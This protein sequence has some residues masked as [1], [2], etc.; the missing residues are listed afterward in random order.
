MLLALELYTSNNTVFLSMYQSRYNSLSCSILRYI[1]GCTVLHCWLTIVLH[2]CPRTKAN[3]WT[4][5]QS[6]Y[7]WWTLNILA[8][9]PWNITALLHS[10]V[11]AL[12]LWNIIAYHLRNVFPHLARFVPAHFLGNLISWEPDYLGSSQHLSLGLS[13]HFSLGTLLHCIE[14][15]LEQWIPS[16]NGIFTGLH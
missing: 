8:L 12:F 7:S 13:Q 1:V 14:G 3:S 2:F 4:V 6:V 10:F 11:P 16:Q 5:M 15:T 9:F